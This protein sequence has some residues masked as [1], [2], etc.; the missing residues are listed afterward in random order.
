MTYDT[1]KNLPVSGRYYAALGVIDALA[2]KPG[3]KFES[4]SQKIGRKYPTMQTAY[5]VVFLMRCDQNLRENWDSEL[6][7]DATERLF[8]IL[9]S[10]IA[11]IP[12]EGIK[13]LDTAYLTTYYRAIREAT[14]EIRDEIDTLFPAI[15]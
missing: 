12:D 3:P 8:R 10:L 2:K 11:S 6:N 13:R 4:P 1:Y 14:E 5:P 9:V 7:T 15:T